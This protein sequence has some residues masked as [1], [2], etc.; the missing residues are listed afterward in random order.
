[1]AL[2]RDRRIARYRTVPPTAWNFAPGGPAAQ[3][4]GAGLAGTPEPA[5]AEE[6]ARLLVTLINPCVPYA[7]E[8]EI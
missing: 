5:H 6:A 8:L 1:V 3:A 4:L 7:L 2:D